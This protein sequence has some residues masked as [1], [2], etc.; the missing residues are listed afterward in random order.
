MKAHERWVVL[1]QAIQLRGVNKHPGTRLLFS[2]HAAASLVARGKARYHVPSAP[3]RDTKV[4][5]PVS[6]TEEKARGFLDRLK[7]LK[8]TKGG[9]K[10]AKRMVSHLGVKA[11]SWDELLEETAT[12]LAS[13]GD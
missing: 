1:T 10:K 6:R 2:K 3:Q 4:E 8:G 7:S 9:F 13:Q 12:V 11:S 5:E